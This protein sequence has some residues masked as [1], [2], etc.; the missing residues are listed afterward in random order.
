MEVRKALGLGKRDKIR[1]TIS[2]NGQVLLSR[3]AQSEEDPALNQFLS[4][5]ACDISENPHHIRAVDSKLINRAQSLVAEVELD[6][7]FPL[8]DEDE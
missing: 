7:D 3:V 5:L 2:S 1:Y 8:S 4:F 6:L